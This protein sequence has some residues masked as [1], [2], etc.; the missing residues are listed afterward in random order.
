MA[1]T[2]VGLK[3]EEIGLSS[4]QREQVLA[5]IRVVVGEAAH[6]L[7]CGMEGT[8]SL[9]QS[10]QMYKLLDENGNVLTGELDALPYERLEE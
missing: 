9:G 3:L 1:G 7:I 2:W 5:R 8:A 4:E 6:S 10:H